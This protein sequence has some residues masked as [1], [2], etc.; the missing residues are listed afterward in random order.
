M[1]HG[2]LTPSTPSLFLRE[3]CAGGIWG[4]GLGGLRN[5]T[6]PVGHQEGRAVSRAPDGL[7]GLLP[8]E[9]GI[10]SYG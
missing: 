4:E 2:C 1:S 7:D 5:A 3:W 6:D 9:S 10:G 8:S